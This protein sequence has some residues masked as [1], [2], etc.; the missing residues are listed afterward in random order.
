[1]READVRRPCAGRPAAAALSA[2]TAAAL[3]LAAAPATPA[4]AQGATT[5][6]LGRVVD[7]NGDPVRDVRIRILD[8][9][10][11]EIFDSGD[12]QLQLAGQ[13]TRV[14]VEVLDSAL[15]VVYPLK[16][17][18]AV[19]RDPDVRVP[20]VVGRSERQLMSDVLATRMVQVEQALQRN[21]VHYSASMDSLTDGLRRI[22]TL[23]ELR[24]S[25]ME[26][27]L[28]RRRSQA[29]IKPALLRI[30]DKYILELRDLRDAFRL[31]VPYAA[32]NL[33]AVTALKQ[34]MVEYNAAFEELNNNRGAFLSALRDHW[35]PATGALLVR[36]LEDVYVQ[37]ID[38]IHRGY[39]LPLN[40]SLLVLQLAHTPNKPGRERIRQAVA[41]AQAVART[42]DPRIPVL[43]ERAR[44][45]REALERD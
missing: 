9:G 3:L 5:R 6:L 30:V 25:D 20:I 22:A 42:L 12:F 1:M 14:E 19:P 36:D 7:L 8:H 29:D 41:D 28:Q 31:V 32:T 38:D 4:A 26:Q 10:E 17:L 23:L 44:Q 2:I 34:A 21:G 18:V 11:P 35:E 13:P 45:L 16:G 15:Q 24:E 43:E 37:A 39:V 27:S 33:D 40:E